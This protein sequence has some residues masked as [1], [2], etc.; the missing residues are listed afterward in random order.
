MRVDLKKKK[1][2][3]RFKN[4][5]RS[6]VL[7]SAW[8]FI[9]LIIAV[10]KKSRAVGIRSTQGF[11]YAIYRHHVQ[12]SIQ[13]TKNWHVGPLLNASKSSIFTPTIFRLP[14]IVAVHACFENTNKSRKTMNCSRNYGSVNMPKSQNTL[15]YVTGAQRI[16]GMN[17]N[18]LFCTFLL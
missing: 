11:A 12:C 1:K 3:K 5:R 9:C 17:L 14:Q 18:L 6:F 4:T 8:F 2:K 15:K 16:Y 10:S 7:F 13:T